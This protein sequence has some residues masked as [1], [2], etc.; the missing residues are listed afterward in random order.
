MNTAS[1]TRHV[2]ILFL[3]DIVWGIGRK[4]IND[5]DFNTF[6]VF[7]VVVFQDVHRRIYIHRCLSCIAVSVFPAFPYP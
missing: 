2:F 5:L 3:T 1:K 4:H 7:S 6:A